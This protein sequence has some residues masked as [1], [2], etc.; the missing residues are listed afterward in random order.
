MRKIII[1]FVLL[2]LNSCDIFN[3]R[4]AEDPE[5]NRS[6]Y[7]PPSE[8]K[9]LIQNL[10]NSF[11]DKDANNYVKSF[12][13]PAFSNKPFFFLPTSS[14]LQTWS[15][16]WIDWNVDKEF[17]YFQNLVTAAPEDLPVTLSFTN[18][19]YSP[20]GDSSNYT[21]EYSISVP[22]LNAES[23]NYRGNVKF[24]MVRDMRDTWAIYF[25]QD[26]AISDSQSWSDL[27]GTSY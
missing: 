18:E 10:V 3:T 8:R 16:L 26:N 6:N 14:A 9:I 11:S 2:S 4:D 24:G 25:W 17:Q 21:A 23:L 20:L 12:T 7:T 15:N 19:I 5:D 13:D 22:Q 1:I 27:K